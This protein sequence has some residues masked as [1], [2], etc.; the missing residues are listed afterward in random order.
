MRKPLSLGQLLRFHIEELGELGLQHRLSGSRDINCM[1]SC[2]SVL[3]Q[4]E[5][6]WLRILL[7]WKCL[8]LIEDLQAGADFPSLLWVLPRTISH[9]QGSLGPETSHVGHQTMANIEHTNNENLCGKRKVG[10]FGHF[11]SVAWHRKGV[12]GLLST[13]SWSQ[14]QILLLWRHNLPKP[15]VMDV[16]KLHKDV[17]L[18]G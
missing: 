17:K 13:K 14:S 9:L 10:K 6:F 8:T 16:L 11:F 3:N 1:P 2:F 12:S 18:S 5:H 4:S 7:N 15:H